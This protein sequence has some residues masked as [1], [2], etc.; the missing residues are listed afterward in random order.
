[1]QI[2]VLSQNTLKLTLSRHDMFDLDINYESL[3]GKNPDTKRLL[4]NVLSTVKLDKSAGVDF[5]GERLFVEAFPRP[6]GGCMLYI[7]CLTDEGEKKANP[8]KTHRFHGV[9]PAPVTQTRNC[10]FKKTQL[11]RFAGVSELGGACAAIAYLIGTGRL[12]AESALY[13]DGSEYRLFV[14][15]GDNE[16]HELAAMLLR[17]YGEIIDDDYE[18][19]ATAEHFSLIVGENAA[20]RL[21][22]VL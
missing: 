2:D 18:T 17:E 7:S 3:S 12:K 1:M 11:C 15:A 5:S 20:E 14:T 4:S 21:N 8:G 6:D 9:R 19:A 16:Q 10:R 22:A 13:G